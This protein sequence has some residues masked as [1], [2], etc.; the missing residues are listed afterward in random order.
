MSDVVDIFITEPC[1]IKNRSV[2]REDI[3]RVNVAD[4]RYLVGIGKARLYIK[5]DEKHGKK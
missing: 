5:G 4:A 2:K 3:V 1:R